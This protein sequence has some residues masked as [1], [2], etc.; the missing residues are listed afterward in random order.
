M[1]YFS[2]I[3]FIVAE[4]SGHGAK[5]NPGKTKEMFLAT[6]LFAT[7]GSQISAKTSIFDW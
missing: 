7:R 5:Y 1:I 4:L 2:V 3:H 6:P